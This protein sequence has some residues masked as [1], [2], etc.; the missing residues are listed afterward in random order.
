MQSQR[1][2]ATELKETRSATRE[3][4]AGSRG[5]EDKVREFETAIKIKDPIIIHQAQ[6]IA[7]SATSP[8]MLPFTEV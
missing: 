4:G 6:Q 5:Y 2:T 8:A 1:H 7:D 3:K